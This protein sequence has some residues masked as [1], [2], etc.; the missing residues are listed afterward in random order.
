MKECAELKC[1]CKKHIPD[2]WFFILNLKL[3]IC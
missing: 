1:Y 2:M 3:I